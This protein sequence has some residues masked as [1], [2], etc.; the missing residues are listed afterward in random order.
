M[1]VKAIAQV[2]KGKFLTEEVLVGFGPLIVFVLFMFLIM[3]MTTSS[4]A[5]EPSKKKQ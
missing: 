4:A 2:Q 1:V 3:V 5:V